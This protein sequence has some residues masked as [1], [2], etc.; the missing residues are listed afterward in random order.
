MP[1]RRLSR[2]RAGRRR[3]Q[4][5]TDPLLAVFCSTRSRINDSRLATRC[6]QPA[7]SCVQSNQ[8]CGI[9]GKSPLAL[10][11]I[12][13][14]DGRGLVTHFANETSTRLIADIHFGSSQCRF[15]PSSHGLSID[16]LLVDPPA[17]KQQCR[18]HA[19]TGGQAAA[20]YARGLSSANAVDAR[21]QDLSH[22]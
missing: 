8:A 5:Q 2:D 16:R 17:G 6:V 10:H 1:P 14:D 3:R 4:I 21:V 13:S 11:R 19:R 22:E 12:A 15:S 9:G 18:H 20:N 7:V